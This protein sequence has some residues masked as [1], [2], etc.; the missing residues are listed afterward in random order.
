M[1]QIRQDSL[2]Q[3][4]DF[5]YAYDGSKSKVQTVQRHK[6]FNTDLVVSHEFLA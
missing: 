6:D 2:C 1:S 3:I 5:R 4:F